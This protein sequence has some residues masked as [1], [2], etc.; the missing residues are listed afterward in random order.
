VLQAHIDMVPQAN[1]DTPHDFTTDPIHA[2][3]DG[4]WVRAVAPP[5]APITA[6]APPPAWQYWPTITS[7]M[8][9]WK[10]C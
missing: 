2:Y 8:A 5:S 10:C 7:S 3:V 6:S 1:A 4:E 9:R